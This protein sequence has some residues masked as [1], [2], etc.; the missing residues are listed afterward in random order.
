MKWF[1]VGKIVNTHGVKGEVRIVSTTD[2]A[3]E[4]YEKGNKLYIFKEK[5]SE[6]VEVTV[7]SHRRH[8]NFDL[9]TFE[10]YH[11]V[12]D[13][14]HYKNCE[15]KI[16]EEQL[17]DLEDG[18]FYFHEIIGCTVKTEDGVEV[19]TVKEILTPGANDVWVVKKG[20]KE[21][22]IPYI[23]DV[24]QSIDIDEKEIVITVMEG[25]LD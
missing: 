19:G 25:L 6:P 1:K 12:N 18:E 7:A 2:F 3:D 23:D 4:R 24:V 9:L 11:N 20:G 14:E 17:T 15:V 13:V 21:V 10:G 8:K 5:Q 22:L 16:P